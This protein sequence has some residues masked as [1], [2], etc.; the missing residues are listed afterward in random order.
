MNILQSVN[1][2]FTAL[3]LYASMASTKARATEMLVVYVMIRISE[4][5]HEIFKNLKSKL[6][7]MIIM[8]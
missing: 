8:D 4:V 6:L 3:V 7:P 1:L 5:H 2:K